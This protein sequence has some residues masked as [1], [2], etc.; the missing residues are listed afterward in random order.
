MKYYAAVKKEV[1]Y[2]LT[3]VLDIVYFPL[4]IH[5]LPSLPCF[6]PTRLPFLEWIYWGSLPFDFHCWGW[7]RGKYQQELI[8]WL[9]LPWGCG[10]QWQCSSPKDHSYYWVGFWQHCPPPRP[11]GRGSFSL[12]PVLAFCTIPCWCVVM[13]Y[14][15]LDSAAMC[16]HWEWDVIISVEYCTESPRLRERNTSMDCLCAVHKATC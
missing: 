16:D 1:L 7:V 8:P 3:C 15:S 4:Q 10:C 13:F 14:W 11:S 5:Y 12:L 6:G 9:S 2:T